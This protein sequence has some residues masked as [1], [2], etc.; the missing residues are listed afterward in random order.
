MAA[1][2]GK[3]SGSGSLGIKVIRHG[4]WWT[5][6]KERVLALPVIRN[7][8]V[9]LWKVRN[10]L[11]TRFIQG[12]VVYQMARGFSKL[13]GVATC[14]AELQAMLIRKDGTIVNF[15]P[16]SYR[17]VTNAFLGMLIDDLDNG[18]ADI[19]A[20]NFHGCG[21]GTTAE[22]A[23]DTALVTESTTVL[24]TDSTRATGTR[25]QPT[26]TQYRSVATQTFDGSAAITEHGLF[27]DV[28]TGQGNLLDRSVFSAINVVNGDSIQFTYT[29]TQSG[30]A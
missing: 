13:T 16:V 11:T 18:A 12:L 30:D 1:Y 24:Q 3:G 20:F 9:W 6:L 4:S 26:A 21:V 8:E 5:R 27:D 2:E 28:D 25:S 22:S 17:L 23:G 19:S 14:R 29:Y 7:R 15:G 10:A